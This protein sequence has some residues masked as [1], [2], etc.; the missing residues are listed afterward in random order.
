MPPQRVPS[1]LSLNDTS[2]SEGQGK[3]TYILRLKLLMRNEFSIL[4]NQLGDFRRPIEWT[5]L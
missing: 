3:K 4:F 2:L 1:M 5:I